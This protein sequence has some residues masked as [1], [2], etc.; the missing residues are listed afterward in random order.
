LAN[1][2]TKPLANLFT[3]PLA[4]NRFNKLRTEL[5]ILEMKNVV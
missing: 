4:K 2:F 1:L 3:K 5:G